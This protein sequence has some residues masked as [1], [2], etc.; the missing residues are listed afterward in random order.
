MAKA[1]I[2]PKPKIKPIVKW[3]FLSLLILGAI[4]VLMLS[5]IFNVK[6]IVV[7]NNSKVST[8]EIINLSGLTINENIFKFLKLNVINKIEENPY[9]EQVQIK[10]QLPDKILISV[11]ERTP[12]YMLAINQTYA[13]INNQGYILELSSEP[14][15]LPAI[16]GYQTEESAIKPGARL[17][18]EDLNTL[19]NIIQ[20][21]NIARDNDILDQITG[22]IIADDKLTLT[23]QNEKVAYIREMTNINIKIVNLKAILEREKDKAGEI[24]LDGVSS[25]NSTIFFRERV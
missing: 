4:I 19:E 1:P 6:E 18:L 8:E 21:T 16:S 10:R 14:L 20:I 22:F 5:P 15:Q 25:E 3:V 12:T 13:Y 9:I 23:L 24:F 11:V 7:S 2:K 17:C